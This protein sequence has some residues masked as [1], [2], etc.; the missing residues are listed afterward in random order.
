M[1]LCA[2]VKRILRVKGGVE[3]LSGHRNGAEPGLLELPPNPVA[4]Q[5]SGLPKPARKISAALKT[6]CIGVVVEILERVRCK[7]LCALRSVAV[8]AQPR[9]SAESVAS[10]LVHLRH[11]P[12]S[13]SG[14]HIRATEQT[15]ESASH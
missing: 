10:C 4:A 15:H 7:R 12:R 8:P 14:R 5:R 6:S 13:W 3:N 11:D 9:D 1:L 2:C